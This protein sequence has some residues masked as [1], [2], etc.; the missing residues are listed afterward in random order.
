MPK[1]LLLCPNCALI[2]AGPHFQTYTRHV[3]GIFLDGD[4]D[5]HPADPII[6]LIDANSRPVTAPIKHPIA[7][8][9]ASGN[10]AAGNHVYCVFFAN[11][12]SENGLFRS[13]FVKETPNADTPGDLHG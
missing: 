8:N 10:H 6:W 12:P 5:K 9:H 13:L 3:S 1:V 2:V 4:T 7:G 11:R